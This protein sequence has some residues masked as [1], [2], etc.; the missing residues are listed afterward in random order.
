MPFHAGPVHFD[1]PVLASADLWAVTLTVAAIV[2]VFWFKIGV[3]PTFAATSLAGALLFVGG[4]V[5]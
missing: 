2:A 5:A 3:I 1:L 4:A